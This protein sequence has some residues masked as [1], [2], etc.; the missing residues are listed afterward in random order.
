MFLSFQCVTPSSVIMDLWWDESLCV[1]YVQ[2]LLLDRCAARISVP[3]NVCGRVLVFIPVCVCI[4]MYTVWMCVR[5]CFSVGALGE[6]YKA[7][8]S[9][10]DGL[11]WSDRITYTQWLTLRVCVYIYIWH[12][13]DFSGVKII[14]CQL[15]CYNSKPWKQR[16]ERSNKSTH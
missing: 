9:L 6:C 8:S 2:L 15:I 7:R 11:L 1:L 10:T 5:V 16:W 3:F 4:R 12:G 14:L 13:A